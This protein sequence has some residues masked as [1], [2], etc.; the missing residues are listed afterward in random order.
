MYMSDIEKTL[1]SWIVP[2]FNAGQFI[3]HTIQ[4]IQ[5]QTFQDWEII[6]VDDCSTDDTAEIVKSLADSDSR[7]RLLKME[8]PSG[9]AI[10][11][12]KKGILNARAE[13]VAP[14]DADDFVGTD[15][16]C[17]LLSIMEERSADVVYPVMYG[18]NTDYRTP[19]SDIY[20]G[21]FE[22]YIPGHECVKL[23]LNGW[24][25][26]CNGGVLKKSL[27]LDVFK[28]FPME[29]NHPNAD[30]LL[31]RHLLYR[32]KRVIMSREKYY[33]RI[34]PGQS[35][36]YGNHRVFSFMITDRELLSFTL[37]HYGRSSEEYDL[38]QSQAFYGIFRV[39]RL[40][41][42]YNYDGRSEEYAHTQI[43]QTELMLDRDI[44][45]K[46]V[47]CKY[48]RLFCLPRMLRLPMLKIIDR[49]LGI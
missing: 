49:V 41:N 9:S 29:M 42:N 47:S 38:A 28:D 36:K 12:R 8:Y 2:A 15:Y 17:N 7:I 44:L 4:S 1:V 32:A 30:E 43:E 35:D 45:R 14:L 23:T 10:L 19:I 22:K 31:T 40:L 25:I 18:S 13:I 11:P 48:Y 37:K 3:K 34:H 16:L 6:V 24:R 21:L 46:H 27:Y 5:N 20:P 26:H 39:L 33:Y